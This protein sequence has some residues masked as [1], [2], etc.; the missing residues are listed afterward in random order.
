[1]DN[2]SIPGNFSGDKLM[3][4][5]ETMLIVHVRDRGGTRRNRGCQALIHHSATPTSLT[6]SKA[7]TANTDQNIATVFG[8]R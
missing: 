6:S 4:H 7:S 2:I 3:G 8:R 5:Y 1:M